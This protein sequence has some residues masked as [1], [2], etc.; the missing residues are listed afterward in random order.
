MTRFSVILVLPSLAMELAG[1][2][3]PG[4]IDALVPGSLHRREGGSA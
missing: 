1:L 2:L 3:T 4:S